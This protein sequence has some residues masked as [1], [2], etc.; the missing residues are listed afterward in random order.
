[1]RNIGWQIGTQGFRWRERAAERV[2][3]RRV[4]SIFHHDRSD[5]RIYVRGAF[6]AM[7]QILVRLER[8][9]G[10][11]GS[12]Y[13]HVECFRLF[14]FCTAACYWFSASSSRLGAKT[15]NRDDPTSTADFDPS[16]SRGACG[17]AAGATRAV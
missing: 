12:G 8:A 3:G 5:T 6:F 11:S 2:V 17:S 7:E 13:P 4:I 14:Q 16:H 9:S 10:T 1:M 15:T